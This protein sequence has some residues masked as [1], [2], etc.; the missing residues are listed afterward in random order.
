MKR[1]LTIAAV[2]LASSAAHAGDSYSFEIGGRTVHIEAPSD[3]DSPSCVSVN[4]PGV[5]EPAPKRG[6]RARAN[7]P[8]PQAKAAPAP[9]PV[10]P[11]SRPEK[12]RDQADRIP[13]APAPVPAAA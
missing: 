3:C 4:I 5:Y 10:P 12:P 8:E 7:A 6:T 13:P 11:G 2:L 1:L 9:R